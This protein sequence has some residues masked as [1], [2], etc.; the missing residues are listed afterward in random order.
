MWKNIQKSYDDNYRIWKY[1]WL[2]GCIISMVLG[3]YECP[4]SPYNT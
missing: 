2:S 4:F 1:M 3:M